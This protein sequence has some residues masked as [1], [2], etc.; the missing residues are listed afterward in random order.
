MPAANK[1]LETAI[2]NFY[3]REAMQISIFTFID[4]YRFLFES[5]TMEE[6][7]KAYMKRYKINEELYSQDTVISIYYRVNKDL[8]DLHK[9]KEDLKS[10]P[11]KP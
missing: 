3:R 11:I 9:N 6:A 8:I 10:F 1:Y 5:V 2:E 4:T 7:A